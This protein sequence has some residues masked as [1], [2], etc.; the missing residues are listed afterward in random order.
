[1]NELYQGDLKTTR[2]PI[3]LKELESIKQGL[4]KLPPDKM[5]WDIE[6]LSAQPP[7]GTNISSDINNFY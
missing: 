5:I 3:T 2:I 6:N 1:M 7:W 4:A